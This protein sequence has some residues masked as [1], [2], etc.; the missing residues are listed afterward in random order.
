MVF[1]PRSE[2]CLNGW[3]PKKK[4]EKRRKEANERKFCGAG[5]EVNLSL[6][7]IQNSIVIFIVLAHLHTVIT[8]QFE[9]ATRSVALLKWLRFNGKMY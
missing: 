4:T 9:N 7:P 5:K 1:R 8:F 6:K 2:Q 3:Q